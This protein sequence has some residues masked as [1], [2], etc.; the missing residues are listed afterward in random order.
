MLA[1]SHLKKR[2]KV[3]PSAQ[4]WGPSHGCWLHAEHRK[5]L[6]SKT[7]SAVRLDFGSFHGNGNAVQENDHQD[8]MIKHLVC[9][10]FIAHQTKSAEKEGKK[11]KKKEERQTSY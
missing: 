6:T 7:H 9:Y 5:R 3:R 10:D 11:K 2:K 4:Q 1:A 8:D